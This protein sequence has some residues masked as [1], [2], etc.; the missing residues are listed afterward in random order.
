MDYLT[1]EEV[2]S[3]PPFLQEYIN[4][5]DYEGLAMA[6]DK[7]LYDQRYNKLSYFEPYAFQ[8]KMFEAGKEYK[9]RFACLANRIGKTHSGAVEMAVHLT[10]LYPKW[11]NGHRFTKPIN[12]WALGITNATTAEVLQEKIMGTPKAKSL[13]DIGTG[14]IPRDTIRFDTMTRDGD[15]I[16]NVQVVW[17][18]EYKVPCG[19]STLTFKSTEQGE[20]V[21]MGQSVD[22]ILMDEEPPTNS[23]NLYAQASKRTMTTNGRVLITATPENG[24][25]PLIQHFTDTPELFIFHAGWEDCPHLSEEQ[26]KEMYAN[27]PE[28]Q[29]DSASK[30]LPAKGSGAIF[31]IDDEAISV[32]PFPIPSDWTIV[33]GLDFGRSRDPST[34]V[35]AAMDPYTETIYIFKEHYLNVDRSPEAMARTILKGQYPSI[36]LVSPHDGNGVSTDGGDETRAEIMR[37]LGARVRRKTFENTSDIKLTINNGRKK[38]LGKESGLAW[39]L[40]QMKAGKL[41][42]FSDCEWFFKE[43]R[44][45]FYVM[46][47]GKFFPR[48]GD[49]HIMDAARIAVISIGRYGEM[50]MDC[51]TKPEDYDE[52]STTELNTAGWLS[53]SPEWNN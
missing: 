48:D 34:I 10:G 11:W 31:G 3:L 39:M 2:E 42:V 4:N 25:T 43:K 24:Y 5:D 37:K 8:M 17:H 41:K 36:P 32:E 38:S 21:M 22:F 15:V 29:H 1:K 14:F 13:D 49:D 12:A 23:L 52:W 28:W 6:L 46:K 45:Y 40:S 50:A 30:G 27:L 19:Y 18:N 26:K 53:D 44:S 16:K 35:C 51:M 47:N 7:V 9:G 20:S 33:G